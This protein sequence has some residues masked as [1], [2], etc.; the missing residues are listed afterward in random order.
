MEAVM[1]KCLIFIT[2]CS[3]LLIVGCD[4]GDLLVGIKPLS[5]SRFDGTFQFYSFFKNPVNGDETLIDTRYVFN[6]TNKA[7]KIYTYYRQ[8]NGEWS[9]YSG[10]YPGDTVSY[11]MEANIDGVLLRLKIWGYLAGDWSEIN[12]YE[13]DDTGETLTFINYFYDGGDMVL[14]KIP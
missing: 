1:R 14:H 9:S 4:L 10:D 3:M 5:D 7:E 6:G 8:E 13:F 12:Q 2:A 11:T